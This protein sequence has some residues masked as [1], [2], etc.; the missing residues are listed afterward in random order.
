MPNVDESY[1]DKLT[2]RETSS[3]IKSCKLYIGNDSGLFHL[4]AAVGTKHVIIFINSKLSVLRRYRTT[5]PLANI[6]N[7]IIESSNIEHCSKCD[8]CSNAINDIKPED[9]INI[10]NQ[11]ALY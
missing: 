7:C 5:Y 11:N 8:Q 10:M 1:L 2:I 9:V 3:V 4:S 6:N